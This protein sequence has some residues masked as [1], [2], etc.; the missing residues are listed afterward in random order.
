MVR[1]GEKRE[2]V[3]GFVHGQMEDSHWR[4]FKLGKELGL[5]SQL[6][7]GRG[8]RSQLVPHIVHGNLFSIECNFLCVPYILDNIMRE[9][10]DSSFQSLWTPPPP[11]GPSRCPQ[12]TAEVNQLRFLQGS[13]TGRQD[14]PDGRLPG[15]HASHRD[16]CRSLP[17]TPRGDTQSNA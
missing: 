10:T 12:H 8:P 1:G 2:R 6:G 4:E 15:R 9:K 7:H 3:R 13:F 5:P 11:C 16:R 14:G 17:P